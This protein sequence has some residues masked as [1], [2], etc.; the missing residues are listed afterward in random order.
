MAAASSSETLV[1]AYKL[2]VVTTTNAAMRASDHLHD[3]R[4]IFT[5]PTLSE[6]DPELFPPATHSAQTLP[7]FADTA[8]IFHTTAVTQKQE[9]M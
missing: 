1:S 9:F 4:H 3:T 2:H 6:K 8:I 5:Y 7:M